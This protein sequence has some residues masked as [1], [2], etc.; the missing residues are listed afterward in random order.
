MAGSAGSAGTVTVRVR[1]GWAV[2]D[3]VA[4]RTGGARLDVDPDLAARWVAAGWVE[5]VEPK[6]KRPRR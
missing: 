3:G 1:D 4:Q 6:A 5:P 2:Y